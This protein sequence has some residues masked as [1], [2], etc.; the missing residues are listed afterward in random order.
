MSSPPKKPRRNKVHQ[1]FLFFLFSYF[2]S[3]CSIS[4]SHDLLQLYGL[5]SGHPYLNLVPALFAVPSIEDLVSSFFDFFSYSHCILFF[6]FLGSDRRPQ[7]S[8]LYCP[9]Y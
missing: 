9:W 8:L 5:H 7:V 3:D 4:L 6:F 1:S 2:F